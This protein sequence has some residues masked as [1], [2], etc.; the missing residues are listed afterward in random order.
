MGPEGELDLK[1]D[2]MKG[3]KSFL[4]RRGLVFRR[5]KIDLRI[6]VSGK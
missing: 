5:V 3:L 1:R 2:G 6:E 4:S